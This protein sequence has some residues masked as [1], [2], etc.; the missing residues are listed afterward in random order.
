MPSRRSWITWPISCTNRSRTRP[1][2]K[3][4]PHHSEYA[5]TDTSAVPAEVSTF[6]FGSRRTS[7]LIAPKNLTISAPA[8]ASAP[9]MRERALRAARV[10][11]VGSENASRDPAG[12]S[13]A[14]ACS[15]EC[16]RPAIGAGEGGTYVSP[17]SIRALW[18]QR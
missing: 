15:D 14:G 2:A 7:P 11:R 1:T 9:L 17:L 18:Q 3:R 8:A 6:S 10:V 12:G 5:A 13:P 16:V 4:Q